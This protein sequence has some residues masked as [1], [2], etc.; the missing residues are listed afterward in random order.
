M[1]ILGYDP[2][3]MVGRSAKTFLHP[4]DLDNSRNEMRLA[5]RGRLMRNFECRYVH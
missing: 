3:E 2:N 4:D 5:R 1:T